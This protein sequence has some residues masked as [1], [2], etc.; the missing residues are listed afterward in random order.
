MSEAGAAQIGVGAGAQPDVEARER[1]RRV[2][3][4]HEWVPRLSLPGPVRDQTIGLLHEL[5]FRAAWHQVARMPESA[6]LGAV[7][8]T[9][10]VHA[11][12]D[13]ATVSVLARLGTFEGR[14]KF[15]TWAYKFGILHAGVELRRVAWRGREIDLGSIPEPRATG[16]TP[17]GQ[18]EG[19]D[20][21]R[22][23]RQ[24]LHE[25][26]T[27]HQRRIAVAL[28]VDEVPIDVLAERLGTTRSAL[29]KTLHE[30]RKRLRVF[31]AD[32]GYLNPPASKEATP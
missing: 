3:P 30:V 12:A 19:R 22:A 8:R 10:I 11:A 23:V 21:A 9:E 31:L 5:L 6:A 18:A 7:R 24:G 26:L 28:L 2:V 1:E 4:D 32:Q 14:S 20:L 17:E 15:T 25:A 16:P 29:Y 13:E 27:P